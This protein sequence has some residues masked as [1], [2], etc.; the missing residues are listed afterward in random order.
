MSAG[1]LTRVDMA[2]RTAL[3]GLSVV[4]SG[5]VALGV[6]SVGF[7][8]A[9]GSFVADGWAVGMQ[10]AAVGFPASVSTAG[11]VHRVE[12]TLLHIVG[13]SRSAAVAASG[14]TV[15]AVVPRPILQA[16]EAWSPDAGAPYSEATIVGQP[17]VLLGAPADGSTR[18][19]RGL[20][21]LG[22]Y[23]PLDVG[24]KALQDT[25]SAVLDRFPPGA[26]LVAG[27]D[28]VRVRTDT[29]GFH[30]E[31]QQVDGAHARITVTVPW[32]SYR[33]NVLP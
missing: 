18:E 28:T 5:G 14:R 6:S 30:S 31:V 22:V 33:T 15:S 9:S 27:A 11:V 3:A 4:S 10:F 26:S 29:S 19:D 24:S 23:G 12:P 32:H 25:A 13:G 16:N 2:F 8:R 20:L 1:F 17:A 21:V 7:T